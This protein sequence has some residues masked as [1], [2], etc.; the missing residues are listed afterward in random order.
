MR[1]RWP[2]AGS[3]TLIEVTLGLAI[4]VLIFGIIFQLV[5]MAVVGADVAA[6]NSLRTR[7]VS[8]FFALVRQ[9]CLDLPVRSQITLEPR[10][11]LKGYDLVF[12]NAP[13]AILPERKDGIRSLRLAL[14]RD[15]VGSGGV[16]VLQEVFQT[17]NRLNGNEPPQTNTFELMKD[18]VSAQ[19]LAFDP[20]DG[21]EKTEWND[22]IK[23]AGLK[24]EL[25]RW[26]AGQKR[27]NR[28]IFWI[29]TGYGPS[30]QSP[31][32]PVTRTPLAVTN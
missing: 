19:W 12:S 10:T 15:A 17:T 5:Q 2:A 16:L 24:L 20:R 13:L 29:P 1:G 28:G 23:P 22:P 31:V 6:K 25:V 32:D 26:D 7:E 8:G 11:G 30:G 21:Q 9:L 3:F 18:M 27:T 4:L 14:V